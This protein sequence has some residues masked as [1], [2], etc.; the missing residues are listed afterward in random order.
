[1]SPT[2]SP[3]RSTLRSHRHLFSRGLCLCC[4]DNSCGGDAITPVQSEIND[5][6]IMEMLASPLFSQQEKAS[7]DQPEIYR[8]RREKFWTTLIF[9]P[10][11]QWDPLAWF[12][13]GARVTV[14]ERSDPP[15]MKTKISHPHVIKWT[16][17]KVHGN[18][19]SFSCLVKITEQAESSERW[20][21][22]LMDFQSTDS[23]HEFYGIDGEPIEFERN[24]FPG[25]TSLELLRK[26]YGDLQRRNI[27]PEKFGNRLV[28][29]SMFN[30]VDS[31]KKKRTKM[32]VFQN[33]EEIKDYAKRFTRGQWTFCGPGSE[34]RWCGT[35]ACTPEGKWNSVTAL[36]LQRFEEIRRPI[37][38]GV[39]ALSCGVRKRKEKQRH[40][41]SHS[42]NFQHGTLILNHSPR[43]STQ[44]SQSSVKLECTV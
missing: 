9:V 33:C 38:T 21:G 16:K 23:I 41:S 26:I 22:Q 15:S 35:C 39:S 31:I 10:I 34:E 29:M 32:N 7:A 3:T 17:A 4:V 5:A 1:M 40:R 43:E 28:F 25:C 8:S 42:G 14:I 6:Q 20:G 24:L 18:S 27:D 44:Y 30:D 19:D 12:H 13:T 2:T 11:K 37:N 36:M